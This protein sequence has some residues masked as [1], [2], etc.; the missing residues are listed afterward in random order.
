MNTGDGHDLFTFAHVLDE[1]LLFFLFFGLRA[2]EEHPE[3]QDDHTHEDQRSII[4]QGA[5]G[6]IGTACSGR[7]RTGL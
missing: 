3:Y 6:F 4:A 7:R 5:A 2:D 1:F